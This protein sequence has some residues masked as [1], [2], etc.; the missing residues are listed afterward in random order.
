[1]YSS[2][3]LVHRTHSGSYTT[4]T[5]TAP[6]I[7]TASLPA[8]THGAAYSDLLTATGTPT[9]TWTTLPA[10]GNG[11]PGGLALSSDGGLSGTPTASGTYTFT[12]EAS[13]GITFDEKTFT[14]LV[15]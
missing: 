2:T 5:G 10:T 11:L 6:R 13:D 1:V 3:T 4:P 12:V 7:T 8:G 15:N 14:L 9:I